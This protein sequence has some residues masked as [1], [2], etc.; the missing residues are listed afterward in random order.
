MKK[1][2]MVVAVLLVF[3]AGAS[4]QMPS[5]P[6]NVYAGVGI[7]M[8]TAPDMVKDLQKTGFH[9]QVG[10]GFDVMP[11]LQVIGK[12]EY[13]SMPA[14]EQGYQLALATSESID[15]GTLTPW[16]FGADA[17]WSF[18]MPAA[19]ITPY[20]LGGAGLARVSI[21]DVET[22]SGTVEFQSSNELY[23][24]IGVGT[25]FAASPAINLFVQARW[26]NIATEGE[27]TTMI[28]FTAG[29]KF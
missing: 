27:S 7:S 4:A 17:K 9:A 2:L 1:V 12:V 16:L 5:K 6:F 11:T 15:G 20:V 8:L 28:P 23:F 14:D 18:K 19:P 3:A 13:H 24:N 22:P 25:E 21:S 29:I 10:V 26:V